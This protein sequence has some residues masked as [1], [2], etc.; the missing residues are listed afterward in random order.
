MTLA[1]DVDGVVS[2]AYVDELTR[3][4]G[5]ETAGRVQLLRASEA[6]GVETHTL[7]IPTQCLTC[8]PGC[9]EGAGAG[10][11]VASSLHPDNM[12][13]VSY[14]LENVVFLEPIIPE[15]IT[16]VMERGG[17]VSGFL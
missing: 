10:L 13:A 5:A 11:H 9:R 4:S 8:N 1:D 17:A 15:Q 16:T 7:C 3:D 12:H 2:L 6:S 14:S